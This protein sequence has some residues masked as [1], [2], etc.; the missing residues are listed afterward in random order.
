[1]TG[2]HELPGT[3]K[4]AAVKWIIG[5][6]CLK[7]AA[8]ALVAVAAIVFLSPFQSE[9]AQGFREGWLRAAGYTPQQYGSR[10]AGEIVG[11]NL[12]PAVLA[13][14]LLVFLGLRKLTALRVVAGL[15][16][17]GKRVI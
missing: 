3:S 8:F 13:V 12:I 7:L 5:L 2:T 6:A 16:V 4:P 15:T 14:L 17:Q 9:V 11:R 1:M 10:E